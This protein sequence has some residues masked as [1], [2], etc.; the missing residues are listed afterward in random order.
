[1]TSKGSG[2]IERFLVGTISTELS[3]FLRDCVSSY[4]ALESLLLLARNPLESWSAREMA[5]AIGA[6]EESVETALE[7]LEA[8]GRLLTRRELGGA[9]RVQLNWA[10]AVGSGPWVQH[11][12]VFRFAA[13]ALIAYAVLNKN[14]AQAR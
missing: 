2:V 7:E 3:A 5:Q 6:T 13:F 11:A 12:H 10:L 4:E 1:M 9:S 8:S 14:R